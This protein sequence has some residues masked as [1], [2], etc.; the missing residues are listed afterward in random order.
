MFLERKMNWSG[1]E[2]VARVR[3]DYSGIILGI[4]NMYIAE[5]NMSSFGIVD[6]YAAITVLMHTKTL[7]PNK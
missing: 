3:V 6:A 2:I 7:R 4:I 5:S 1:H